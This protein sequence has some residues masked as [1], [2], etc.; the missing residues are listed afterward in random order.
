MCLAALEGV[1]PK[2]DLKQCSQVYTI[3]ARHEVKLGA[4]CG[5]KMQL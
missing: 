3:N 1:E 4:W 5:T 2:T